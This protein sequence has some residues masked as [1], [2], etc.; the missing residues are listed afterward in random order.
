M[1]KRILPLAFFQK[2]KKV[3]TTQKI[4]VC[5]SFLL[6]LISDHDYIH[7]EA[8]QKEEAKR[9]LFIFKS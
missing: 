1:R 6:Y 8:R 9:T 4:F 7:G 2:K 5:L 3:R